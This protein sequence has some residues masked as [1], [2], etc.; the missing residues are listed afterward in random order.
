MDAVRNILGNYL[1]PLSVA[2]CA[3]VLSGAVAMWIAAKKAR[4]ENA[5]FARTFTASALCEAVTVIPALV[6]SCV[7]VL[8]TIFGALIGAA[9]SLLIVKAIFGVSHGKAFGVWIGWV[10]AQVVAAAAVF[11]GLR[12]LLQ[13]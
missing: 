5:E 9:L 4:L 2:A 1:L 8:G 7:P 12:G 3:G 11:L 6:F 10:A 13:R